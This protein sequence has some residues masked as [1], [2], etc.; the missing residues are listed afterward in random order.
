VR[1]DGGTDWIIIEQEEYPNGMGQL[2]TVAAS[3]KGLQ[4]VIA[5]L[6]AQ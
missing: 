3:L 2:E 6:P 5:R 1:Q 4:A